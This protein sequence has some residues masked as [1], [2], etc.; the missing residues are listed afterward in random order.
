MRVPQVPR[1]WGPGKTQTSTRLL[2]EAQMFGQLIASPDRGPLRLDLHGPFDSCCVVAEARSKP[3]SPATGLRRWGGGP[4]F[5]SS[6]EAA[7]NRIPPRRTK[8]VRRGLRITVHVAKLL[9]TLLLVMHVEV[10]VPRLP[11]GPLGAPHSHGEFQRVNH[12]GNRA[13]ERLT[14]EQVQVLGHRDVAGNRK[15]VTPTKSAPAPPQR[16]RTQPA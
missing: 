12:A 15:A 13:P 16:D 14:D 7:H 3:G 11:E 5:G 4:F 10:V 8:F 2:R 1:F 6:N 9:D